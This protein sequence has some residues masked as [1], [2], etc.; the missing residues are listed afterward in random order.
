MCTQRHFDVI[1]IG[2]GPGGYVGA[3]RATQLGFKEINYSPHV[4][5]LLVSG[6]GLRSHTSVSARMFKALAQANINVEMISTSEVR[7][8][9]VVA[10]EQGNRGLEALQAAFKSVKR[11]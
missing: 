3:I 11:M 6:I 4:C 10:G 5:K 2:S 1:V 8:N 9:M 7:V